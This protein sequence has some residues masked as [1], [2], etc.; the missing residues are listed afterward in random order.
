MA[1]IIFL[2]FCEE[3]V[4]IVVRV[5]QSQN[6]ITVLNGMMIFLRQSEIAPKKCAFE[7]K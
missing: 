1:E 4:N 7:K 2:F 5:I 3:S 6:K